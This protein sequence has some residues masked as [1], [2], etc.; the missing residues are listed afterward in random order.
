MAGFPVPVKKPGKGFSLMEAKN[1]VTWLLLIW[2][3]SRLLQSAKDCPVES[4]PYEVSDWLHGL[5]SPIDV[6]AR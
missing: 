3:G 1:A 6:Q 2:I 4:N 5:S